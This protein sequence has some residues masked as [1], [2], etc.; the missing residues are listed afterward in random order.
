[1]VWT[2]AT[3]VLGAWIGDDAPKDAEL[4]EV[5]VGKAERLIRRKIPGLLVRIEVEEP[6]L[7][8]NVKDVVTAM[9]QRVFRNPEG[10]RQANTTT[11]P[12]TESRTYGGDIPGSLAIT[13][14]ELELLAPIG[15]KRRGHASTVDMI[16]DW[17]PYYLPPAVIL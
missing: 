8:D 7:L 1:M 6:D 3:D 9:V 5:W 17:S 11:G 15:V 16:P 4:V 12:F 14:D 2:S 10:I 13:A